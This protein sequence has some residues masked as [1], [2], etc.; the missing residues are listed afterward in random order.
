[1]KSP[2]LIGRLMFSVTAA[3]VSFWIVAAVGG[4]MV[5]KDEFAEIFDSA[6]QETTERL[7]PLIVDDIKH[8]DHSDEVLAL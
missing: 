8:G 7:A 5:M 2:S 3:V 4:I 6:L 1:M